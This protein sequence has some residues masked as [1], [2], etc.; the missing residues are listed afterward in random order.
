MRS[1]NPIA[2]MTIATFISAPAYAVLAPT[3][4]AD[5]SNIELIVTDLDPLDGFADRKSVV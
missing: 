3:A 5:I 1:L 2:F 4:T